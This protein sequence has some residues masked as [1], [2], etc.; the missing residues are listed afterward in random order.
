ERPSSPPAA[1]PRTQS[2]ASRSS[3]LTTSAPR[4]DSTSEQYGPGRS[5]ERSRTRIPLRGPLPNDLLQ[6]HG[7]AHVAL[8]LEL[9]AHERHLRVHLSRDDVHEVGRRGRHRA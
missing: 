8:D 6:L 5:R 2:P 4:S 7:E 9:A 3:T 1:P